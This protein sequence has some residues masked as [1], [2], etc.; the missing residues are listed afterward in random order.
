MP[1]QALKTLV[2]VFDGARARFFE[3]DA[4]GRLREAMSEI[5]PDFHRYTHDAVSDKPG[6]AFASARTGLRHAYEPE[7]DKHKLEKHNFV[8]RL[9]QEIERAYDQHAYERFV[10]VAPKRSL[11]EFHALAPA[12]L[13]RAIWREVPK[14]LTKYSQHDLERRLAPYLETGTS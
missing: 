12:K 2:V 6:R 9:V 10:I 4:G 7:H 1:V 13:K 11:G 14:E 8:H 3:R 5:N